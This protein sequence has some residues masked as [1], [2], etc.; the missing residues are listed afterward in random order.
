[1]STTE[2][3][4]IS[5]QMKDKSLPRPTEA[6]QEIIPPPLI[7]TPNADPSAKNPPIR[8]RNSWHVYYN[9]TRPITPLPQSDGPPGGVKEEQGFLLPEPA[10]SIAYRMKLDVPVK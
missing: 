1:M 6:V 8:R 3:A 2:T 5:T 7:L 10:V 9:F 4:K